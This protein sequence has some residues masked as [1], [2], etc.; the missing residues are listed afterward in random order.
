MWNNGAAAPRADSHEGMSDH[1][2][3][4]LRA[5]RDSTTCLRKESTMEE[6]IQC[7][8]YLD[9]MEGALLSKKSKWD[10]PPRN[11]PPLFER[12]DLPEERTSTSLGSRHATQPARRIAPETNR[13]AG[14][15][16]DSDGLS[17]SS[18]SEDE[19]ESGDRLELDNEEKDDSDGGAPYVDGMDKRRLLIRILN[20]QG[21]VYAAKALLFRK[22][23]PPAWSL[24][25]DQY[26]L[27]LGKVHSALGQADETVSRWMSKNVNPN[28]M[29]L[30]TEDADI[31]DVAVRSMT[32]NRDS[33]L[34]AASHQ[35]AILV[36]H[37]QPHWQSRDEVKERMGER[38]TQSLLVDV[39]TPKSSSKIFAK[40]CSF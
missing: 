32:E 21:E 20:A 15:E 13:Y 2:D 35:E 3:A 18:R 8:T 34:A 11:D 28:T 10:R 25:A 30:L 24:G 16:E 40:P 17:L 23:S 9:K 26:G 31:V 29:V 14:F 37:L 1:S 22:Q 33:F 36:Q 12:N 39:R 27:C 7:T 4:W 19:G 38:W 5:L 6:L